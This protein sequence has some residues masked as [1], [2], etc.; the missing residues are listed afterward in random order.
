[1][2]DELFYTQQLNND[3]ITW[4]LSDNKGYVLRGILLSD[5]FSV[6]I[7]HSYNEGV[8]D[9]GA[10]VKAA[11][12]AAKGFIPY[13]NTINKSG[14]KN[15]DNLIN[16]GKNA[17]NNLS[18]EYGLGDLGNALDNGLRRANGTFISST[19]LIKSFT[20][21]N[22][23]YQFP[24][25]TTVLLHN[26]DDPVKS[27]L[28]KLLNPT[29]GSVEDYGGVYGLQYAPNDYRPDLNV[30]N[31]KDKKIQGTWSLELG[32]LYK[33]DNLLIDNIQFKLSTHRVKSKTG[34][35]SHALY[36]EVTV[37]VIPATYITKSDIETNILS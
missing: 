8:L 6:N 26:P 27:Q 11:L 1:M 23:R 29:L 37:D 20:G 22:V 13:L 15:F 4:R 35:S 30:L 36:A 5:D 21:S 16:Q 12:N 17:L 2:N 33:F 7:D 19:D 31:M 24:S 34:N 3:N 14:N 18:Q 25:L 32:K 28:S 9:P 10:G